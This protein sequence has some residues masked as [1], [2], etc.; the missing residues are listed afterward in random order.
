VAESLF[1]CREKELAGLHGFLDQSLAGQGRVV[2]ITGEPGSGKTALL[3]AFTREAQQRVPDLIVAGGLCNDQAG[4]G[5]PYLPFREVLATLVGDPKIRQEPDPV[6]KTNAGRIKKIV[7]QSGLML[8]E[9]APTLVDVFIPQL[10]LVGVLGA[11]ALKQY[12][13]SAKLEATAKP[14]KLKQS[15][16][17]VSLS[18]ENVFEQYTQYLHKL[19]AH[20]PLLISLDDLQWADPSSLGLLFHLGRRLV[21]SRVLIVGSYR[22][23]EIA[24]GIRGERHP[25]EKLQAEFM[26]LFGENSIDLEPDDTPEYHRLVNAILDAEPNQLGQE[27][28][29]ALSRHTEGNPLFVRELLS[30]LRERGDLVRN[31]AGYWVASPNLDWTRLPPRVQGVI[32]ERIDRLE[33]GLRQVLDFASVQGEQF[34]A[35]VIASLRKVANRELIAALSGELGRRHQLVA[36]VGS[37]RLE[38]GRLEGGRVEGGRISLYRFTHNLVQKYLYQQMD[39][40]ELA[41]LHE[42]VGRLLEQVYAAQPGP[43]AAQLAWHFSQAGVEAKAAQYTL[44]AGEQALAGYAYAE[45]LEY[46]NQ[47]LKLA[48]P[49]DHPSRFRL[50]L[51]REM[52]FSRLGKRPQQW[53]DLEALAELAKASRQPAQQLEVLLRQVQYHL[54]TGDYPRAQTLAQ[55]AIDGASQ[56][57]QAEAEVRG[58]ALL[59]RILFHQSQYEQAR[60]WL[61]LAE[62]AAQEQGLPALQARSR[63]DLGMVDYFQGRYDSAVQRYSQAM[64]QYQELGNEKG[65][66][67]CLLMEG[68][69]HA[70]RGAYGQARAALE[71]ALESC[72]RIGWRRGETYLLGNLGSIALNL[73]QLEEAQNR[74]EWALEICREVSDREGQAIS[75]DTLGL[76]Q[77]FLGIP[78][79]AIEYF[80]QA[81]AIDREIGYQRGEGFVLTHLG[82][83]QLGLDQAQAAAGSFRAAIEMRQTMG[84][85]PG[86]LVDSRA[87][88]AVALQALGDQPA[89]LE[90]ARQALNQLAE[91]GPSQV[92]Y[93]VQ[94]YVLC[95]RVL[96]AAADPDAGLARQSGLALLHQQADSIQAEELR[97]SFLERVPFNRELLGVTLQ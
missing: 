29:Q 68:T 69:V 80:Q 21:D 60:E 51:A 82:H 85:H 97:R 90:Q 8:L 66:V 6:T 9:V 75:L 50:I 48:P 14:G 89:G 91:Y 24:Q 61:E 52:V 22:K 38:G 16:A 7:A 46:L 95:L 67:N 25:L 55:Q 88:L 56:T 71:A 74:H 11:E 47:G 94:V 57:D 23:D 32:Q 96:E 31:R 20:A 42:E 63:Y 30:D 54:E 2:F 12:G 84:S 28:R 37:V 27:F 78:D 44:L 35:E 77:L 64:Q 17:D 18:Q 49:D 34:A 81:L 26:R 36:P 43:V 70:V 13:L 40:I 62:A 83:A 73:G 19:S 72:R 45:A 93:P 3:G 76:V 58:C 1:V 92:E 41:Y 53:Q 10:T 79:R 33:S 5:E 4:V 87:G 59:G 39:P 86:Q 65:Q 15:L